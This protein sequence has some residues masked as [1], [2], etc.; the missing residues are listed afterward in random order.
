MKFLNARH[1]KGIFFAWAQ[2]PLWEQQVGSNEGHDL[3]IHKESW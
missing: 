2:M 1:S 3:T